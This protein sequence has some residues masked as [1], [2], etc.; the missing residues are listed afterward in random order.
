MSRKV[1]VAIATELDGHAGAAAIQATLPGYKQHNIEKFILDTLADEEDVD[2]SIDNVRL[3]G[4]VWFV[5]GT[6][7]DMDYAAVI[8]PIVYTHIETRTG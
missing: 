8:T 7:W 1:L 2:V 4:D 3:E 6:V 5:S